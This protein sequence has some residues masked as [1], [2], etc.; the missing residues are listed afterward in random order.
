MILSLLQ[1]DGFQLKKKTSNEFCG[2]CPRCGGT[3]RFLVWPNQDGGGRFHCLRGCDW[4]GD[5]IEYLRTY[6]KLTFQEAAQILGKP[7]NN[8]D[9]GSKP[10]GGL[11]LAAF[12]SVKKLDLSLMA[13]YGVVQASGKNG[14]P[15]V[16]FNYHDVS[17]K[18]M[19]DATR[20]RFS[21]REKPK[22]KR[23]GKV[24]LYG[25]QRLPEFRVGGWLILFEGESDLLTSWVYNLPAI[26]IPGKGQLK[27]IKPEY[28]KNIHT[29]YIWVE[30]DA[31]ELPTKVAARL[32]GVKVKAIIP[33]EGIKD[34]SQA[35]IKGED[36]PFLV[37]RLKSEAQTVEPPQSKKKNPDH[38]ELQCISFEGL[39]PLEI[40][41]LISDLEL[42]TSQVL[43]I[44]AGCGEYFH[45]PHKV[46]YVSLPVE[47]HIE[48]M[49][50]K[51]SAFRLWIQRQYYSILQ[52][53][54]NR[55]ALQDALGVLE[56]RALFDGPML[57]VFIRVAG[58][59]DKIYLD[60]CNDQWQVVEITRDSW[61]IIDNPP[62]KFTRRPGMLPLPLPERGGS[63][64]DLRPF[65][66]LP[67]G[68]AG[69]ISWKLIISLLVMALR[70][71]GPYP[72][73]G[74]V[75]PQG[76]AKTTLCRMLRA[77]IDP[78]SSPVRSEP[79]ELRDLI[80]SAQNSW[81]VSLDNLTKIPQWLSDA[82]CR[83]ATGGGFSTRTLYSNDDETIFESQRPT[84]MSSINTVAHSQDLADRL[85]F[86]EL[87]MIEESARQ[88]ESII[89]QRFEEAR[90]KI[91]G[92]LLDGVA[93]ALRRYPTL[94][95]SR[96]P[97]MADFAKWA[98]A[99]EAAWG[100]PDGAFMAAYD[101]N[102]A[103]IVQASIEADPVSFAICEFMKKRET[104]EGR[105]ADLLEELKNMISEDVQDMKVGKSFAFPRTANT[106]MRRLKKA[107]V[108]LKQSGVSI[109]YARDMF[110]QK[111]FL[112][113][114]IQDREK[115]IITVNTVICKEYPQVKQGDLAKKIVMEKG[116][117]VIKDDN[118]P[119]L[120]NDTQDKDLKFSLSAYF[121]RYRQV[122]AKQIGHPMQ[123]NRP[124]NTTETGRILEQDCNS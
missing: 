4:R 40:R 9:N 86:I 74:V 57:P 106:L 1:A 108:F 77:L 119:I 114:D 68:E 91:L 44:M 42:T 50:V 15:Y 66:N 2:P 65:L 64:D 115:I 53:A 5:S 83:L 111:V 70:P 72:S 98:T 35:H 89:W 113:S 36:I 67:Q 81:I 85:I 69:E 46:C 7:I 112:S 101:S 118:I 82:L 11:T 39:T 117:I 41:R 43:I 17:G 13:K 76:C 37:N 25:L 8:K 104:W 62:V 55:Q 32:P 90:P 30:P 93:M 73:G 38:V 61:Q 109:A 6:R 14:K 47:G 122:N 99:A 18:I 63:I 54:A 60:L 96:L 19:E 92:A 121:N 26:A 105:A 49:P 16:I 71:N 51:S 79:K 56:A 23:G 95:L 103:G 80:I 22:S 20:F 59:E 29:L 31:P 97:R 58:D 33:P 24:A 88:E 110:G 100:W 78:N 84:L 3:D 94:K 124:G 45:D 75:G 27:T 12:A 116:E 28:F 52:K 34:I 10:T 107:I 48:T 102:R 123:G 21:M 87:A 120:I